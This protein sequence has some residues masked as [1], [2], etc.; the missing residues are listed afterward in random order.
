MKRM[1]PNMAQT[2]PEYGL[3]LDPNAF[4]APSLIT[5]RFEI[6]SPNMLFKVRSEHGPVSFYLPEI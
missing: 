1:W 6:G 3:S 2:T 4:W 5:L